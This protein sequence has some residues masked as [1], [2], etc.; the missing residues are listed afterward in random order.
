MGRKPFEIVRPVPAL[1]VERD[2]SDVPVLL[3]V[4]EAA[5]LIKCSPRHIRNACASK[6]LSHFKLGRG[7]KIDRADLIAYA[8]SRR[9]SGHAT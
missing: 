9:V 5:K 4:D 8:N 7:Y 6:E 1:Q 3:N 2:P